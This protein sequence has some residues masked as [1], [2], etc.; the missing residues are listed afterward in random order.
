LSPIPAALTKDRFYGLRLVPLP[1]L[2]LVVAI[3]AIAFLAQ[4]ARRTWVARLVAV[5]LAVTVG[6][7]F[8]HFVDNFQARGFARLVVFPAGVPSLLRQGFEGGRKIFVTPDE[9]HALVYAKWYAVEH[10]LPVS[11]VDHIANGTIP[12]DG[13]IVFGRFQPCAYV[14]VKFS[15]SDDYWI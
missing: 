11:R 8:A 7:Q 3:P 14:C 15:R 1:V 9:P 2:L 4:A 12:P 10:G 13:A 5:G 6:V